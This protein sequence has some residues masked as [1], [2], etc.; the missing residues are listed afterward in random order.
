MGEIPDVKAIVQIR[1]NIMKGK[2]H[3][4]I[5]LEMKYME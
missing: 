5:M 1:M 3:N 2:N 4:S